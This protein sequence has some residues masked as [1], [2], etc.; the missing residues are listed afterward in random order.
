M[1]TSNRARPRPAARGES[2]VVRL[3]TDAAG[4][5]ALADRLA[6]SLDGADAA[7]AAFARPNGR[8]QVDLHFRMRPALRPLRALIAL[9]GGERLARSIRVARLAPRDWVRSSLVDLVPVRAGRFVV[10]GAHD[11]SR[12]PLHAVA[13]EIEAATAFGTGHHGTTRGCLVALDALARRTRPRRVLDL[14]TGTGVLAIAA[15]KVWHVP[16]LA[17]DI[18]QRAVAVARTNVRL[19]RASPTVTV[20]QAAGLN[21]PRIAARAPY[22]LVLANILLAPLK[23]LAAPIARHLRPNGRVVLSGIL[24]TQAAAAI[25]AYRSQGFVVERALVL[26]GW[27]TLVMRGPRR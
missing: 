25:S 14:G 1:N 12:V 19:N 24:A 23:R 4:A 22:D 18:D 15:A 27:T 7:C 2:Y 21:S 6:E 20:A 9:A 16:V 13:I 8:W 17:S 3:A 5:R 10:H 26:D 11:R